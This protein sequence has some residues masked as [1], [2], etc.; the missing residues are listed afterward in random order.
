M[1]MFLAR[2]LFLNNF[3]S[4]LS[5]RKKWLTLPA[6]SGVTCQSQRTRE[7]SFNGPRPMVEDPDG[8]PHPS[9]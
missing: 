5:G 9:N 2:L 7:E 1:Q 4:R 3:Q 8:K 6:V